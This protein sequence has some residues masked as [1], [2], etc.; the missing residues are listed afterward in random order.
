MEKKTKKKTLRLPS[1]TTCSC[2]THNKHTV[3]TEIKELLRLGHKTENNHHQF[4]FELIRYAVIFSFLFLQKDKQVLTCLKSLNKWVSQFIASIYKNTKMVW[5]KQWVKESQLHKRATW[6]QTD[7]AKYKKK[8]QGR[9]S[10]HKKRVARGDI[11]EQSG[12]T[13]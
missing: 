11:G 12:S 13:C 2:T 10:R 5:S 9:A 8:P 3:I 6:G 4:V 7:A 1:Q